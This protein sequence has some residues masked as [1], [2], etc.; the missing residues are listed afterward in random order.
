MRMFFAGP[1][2]R[3]NTAPP[4]IKSVPDLQIPVWDAQ[5]YGILSRTLPF[6]TARGQ[7]PKLSSYI[8]SRGFECSYL[9]TETLTSL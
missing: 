6:R 4:Q 9:L 3:F 7:N 2:L 1:S 8:V 5:T